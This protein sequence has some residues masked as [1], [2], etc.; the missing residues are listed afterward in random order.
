MSRKSRAPAVAPYNVL[1]DLL[2]DLNPVQRDAVTATDG[3][4]LILAG[5][6]SGKT[7]VLMYRVAYLIQE[8]KVPPHRILAI[9]F[10]NKAAE[11]MK[12]R[13]DRLVGSAQARRAWVMTFHAACARI[14][15][16]EITRLGFR[17]AF[18][19]YDESDS[20]RLINACLKDLD[21]DPKRY[22]P[23]SIKHAVSLAKNE[24]RSP[25]E[26]A[27]EAKTYYE[28]VVADVYRLYEERLRQNNALD[29]DDLIGLTVHLFTLFPEVLRSYQE[30]FAYILV[31]EYQDT[32]RA[33]YLLVSMLAREHRNIAVVGDDDQSVYGWRGADIRNILSFE[34]DFPDARVFR[35][36]QNYRSSQTI[37]E[38][39]NYVITNN[40]QR[41]PK[42]LWTTNARGEAITTYQAENEHDEAGFVAAEIERLIDLE[43]RFFREFAVFYRTHAQSRVFE[44]VFLRAGIPYIVVGGVK[45]YERAE[46]KDVMAYMRLV[47]NSGD[48]VSLQRIINVP[49]RGIGKTSLD[50]LDWFA[51]QEGISL[52]EAVTRAEENPLLTARARR[53]LAEF[54]KLIE[55]LRGIAT[56]VDIVAFAED[57][58]ARTGYL[59]S[60]EDE[61]TFESESRAENVKEF[62]TAVAEFAAAHVGAGLEEFLE[63]VSLLTDIDTLDE[64]GDAVTL[65]TLHNAK[66]LEFPA[67]FIV[68]LEE[69]LFPHSRSFEDE[70]E[71]EEER[72]LCYVGITRAR[73]RLYLTHAW[74]RMLWGA[75]MYSAPSRFLS[76]VPTELCAGSVV[77]PGAA[78]RPDTPVI[79]VGDIVRHKVFGGGVVVDVR[80]G[81]QVVVEFTEVGEKTLLLEYAPLER[82]S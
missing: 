55:G 44:E 5:A 62:V 74:S 20:K 21:H 63:R 54:T 39:A 37:L 25:D 78:A 2:N 50:H 58:I 9:T 33:Q 53:E 48:S 51:R 3:P 61:R 43:N 42:T 52:W 40:R 12:E 38:A 70:E 41:K 60:L 7:R 30:R 67:V 81:G 71:M 35:L 80:S 1:M 24:L 46:I 56:T 47:V 27:R 28:R 29:F 49:R 79:N 10:T 73:E 82:V 22:T 23:A 57:L 11:E 77:E 17:R 26:L 36:E 18:V 31:D 16:D 72:R 32:N 65:M 64:S 69:G 14:L 45:F 8:K 66:G 4:V 19:V 76:E 34:R 68:G 13:V 75:R 6:G 59:K 15:R